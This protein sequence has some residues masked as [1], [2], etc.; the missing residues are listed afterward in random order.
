MVSSPIQ[1]DR[2]VLQQQTHEPTAFS[3]IPSARCTL[4][5]LPSTPLFGTDGIRGEAGTLLTAPLATQVGFWAGQVLRSHG[6]S[7]PIIIGQ[8]SRTSSDMLSA[9]LAAGLT[10]AGLEVWNVGLCPT[11][12][13]AHLAAGNAGGIMISAS[14]NPPGD[15]GIKF[16]N[17]QGTKLSSSIQKEIEAALRSQRL[18]EATAQDAAPAERVQK[19]VKWGKTYQRPDLVE[20][21]VDFLHEPF[22]PHPDLS[23]LRI[24]LDLAWGAATRV[25]KQVFEATG[26]DVVIMHGLPDGDRINVNCG[27]THLGALK[28][29]VAEL[30]ADIG[31]AFDGDAD[32]VMAVDA[33][34]RVI[35]G[36]YILYFW[37]Q[38]LQQAGKL[39]N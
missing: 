17:A 27:S 21:Y 33:K 11:A 30:Q 31:F 2:K 34:G 23:G 36:D 1:K 7:A 24:V 13:V 6:E 26:A 18:S 16:F 29:A 14:H 32:R 38:T 28:S 4:E 3:P 15:N 35:D 19:P 25:A 12:A 10:S 37:G 9:G 20:R 8:D 5:P 22:Q 39:P